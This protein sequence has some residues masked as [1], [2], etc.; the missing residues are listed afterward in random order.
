MAGGVGF[1]ALDQWFGVGDEYTLFLSG[2]GLVVTA[3]LRP[4]GVAG[5]LGDLRGRL[6]LP[7]LRRARVAALQPT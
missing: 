4:E 2:L 7:R 1:T 5:A 3:V 6:V